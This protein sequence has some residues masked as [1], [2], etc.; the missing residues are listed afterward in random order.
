MNHREASKL[1]AELEQGRLRPPQREE[2]ERH[3]EACPACREWLA[4]YGLLGRALAGAA[5]EHPE[6]GEL[7]AWAVAGSGESPGSLGEHLAQCPDCRRDAELVGAALA[8][9]RGDEQREEADRRRLAKRRFALA[10]A[11]AAAALV[12][13]VLGGTL[14]SRP[15]PDAAQEQVLSGRT[16]VGEETFVGPSIHASGVKIESGSRIVFE[17]ED[18][19][20]FGEGFEVA[21]GASLEIGRVG[22]VEGADV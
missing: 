18:L 12:L 22:K 17:A 7:A 5:A 6:A 11:A 19:V 9:A 20:T 1:L 3:L 21:S 15:A 16:L 2:V 10:S 4:A 8:A 13:A 14:I